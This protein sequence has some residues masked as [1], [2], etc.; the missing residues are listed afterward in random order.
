MH[1]ADDH[2]LAGCLLCVARLDRHETGGRSDGAGPIELGAAPSR[3][4][5]SRRRR[6]R[7]RGLLLGTEDRLA[8]GGLVI[9]FQHL[10]PC[11]VEDQD[12]AFARFRA[13]VHVLDGTG[14]QAVGRLA[15]LV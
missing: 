1:R 14:Q 9:E 6:R 8:L 10:R 4:V 15:D 11:P 2:A 13:S 7:P 3:A 12:R 5:R